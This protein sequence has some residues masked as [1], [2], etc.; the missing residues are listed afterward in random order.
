MAL[1]FLTIKIIDI[2][3]SKINNINDINI[4][5]KFPNSYSNNLWIVYI[6]IGIFLPTFLLLLIKNIIECIKKG[7]NKYGK[8]TIN[9][10][11]NTC[12]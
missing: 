4:I 9:K 12:I 3:Y 1:H 6:F 10:Y 5:S 8:F 2:I 7:K 11:N